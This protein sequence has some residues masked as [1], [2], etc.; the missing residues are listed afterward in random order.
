M[1][2]ACDSSNLI[3]CIDATKGTHL[4]FRVQ[5]SVCILEIIK[6]HTRQRDVIYHNFGST[7]LPLSRLFITRECPCQGPNMT[8]AEAAAALDKLLASQSEENHAASCS[9]A[10]R[11]PPNIPSCLSSSAPVSVSPA[12]PPSSNGTHFLE[13]TQPLEGLCL[14]SRTKVR[15]DHNGQ[16]FTCF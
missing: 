14:S 4:G 13:D 16:V 10:S 7:T 5:T 12:S 6:R 11:A 1:R 3:K 9:S 8:L 15:N 2:P